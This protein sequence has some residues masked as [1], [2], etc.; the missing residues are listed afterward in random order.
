MSWGERS[1]IKPCR[2]PENCTPEK[3]NVDCIS[4][5]Y[6]GK[7]PPDTDN[8]TGKRISVNQEDDIIQP[9]KCS[10]ITNLTALERSEAKPEPPKKPFKF[11]PGAILEIEGYIF[12]IKSVNPATMRLKLLEKAK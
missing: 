3:C 8:L 4:Y 2:K 6:D 1:C 9:E 7:T 11:V 5:Q 12:K 10:Q